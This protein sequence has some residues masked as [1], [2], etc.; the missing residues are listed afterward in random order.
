MQEDSH[1]LASELLY[2]GSSDLH[3]NSADLGRYARSVSFITGDVKNDKI[4]LFRISGYVE[5]R[6][7]SVFLST[8]TEYLPHL[9]RLFP[10]T[11]ATSSK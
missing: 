11:A 10:A 3:Q 4:V 9:I 2:N 5:I 1:P 8:L 6:L 7:P